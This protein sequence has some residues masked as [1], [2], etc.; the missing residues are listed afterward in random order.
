MLTASRFT[1]QARDYVR[2]LA[3]KIV[4]IDGEELAD[5]MIEFNVGVNPRLSSP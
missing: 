3:Q 5:L 1:D 4:L 2:H